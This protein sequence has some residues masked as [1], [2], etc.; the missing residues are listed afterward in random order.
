MIKFHQR[1]PV[2]LHKHALHRICY[3]VIRHLWAILFTIFSYANVCHVFQKVLRPKGVWE[4]EFMHYPK[5]QQCAID[6]L[7]IMEYNGILFVLIWLIAHCYFLLILLDYF[8]Y[9]ISF[10]GVAFLCCVHFEF[11]F[12]LCCLLILCLKLYWC[13]VDF[14]CGVL[15][16][17]FWVP[18]RF[19]HSFYSFLFV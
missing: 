3:D 7:D 19:Y 5:Q 6:L 1:M 10:V 18:M 13:S 4:V 8:F 16:I 15:L 2:V 11:P 14:M 9:C 12:Y 17:T